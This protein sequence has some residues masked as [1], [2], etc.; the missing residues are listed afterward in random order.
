M[1]NAIMN[2]Q[3]QTYNNQWS[4]LTD[5]VNTMATQ[6]VMGQ[7]DQ[8]QWEKFIDG[9]VNSSSYKAIQQ[10]FKEAAGNK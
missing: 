1:S 7:I 3:S 9:I 10:E 2:L 5:D 8:A 6:Y 4:V